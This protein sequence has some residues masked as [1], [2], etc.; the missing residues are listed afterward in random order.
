M[1][2][3]RNRKWVKGTE[4]I[5]L[6][7]FLETTNGHSGSWSLFYRERSVEKKS[8]KGRFEEVTC[9][10]VLTLFG[11]KKPT[12]TIDRQNRGAKFNTSQLTT[13]GD[14]IN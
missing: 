11:G 8:Q 13:E 1:K 9:G 6:P 4:T 5:A 7:P 2:R 14:W 12:K 10:E 3:G